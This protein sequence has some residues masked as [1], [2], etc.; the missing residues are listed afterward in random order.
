[1]FALSRTLT[2][3]YLGRH[4]T[5]T[6]LVVVTIALGVAVLVA[7]QALSRGL[8]AAALRG[9]NPLAVL[10][11]LMIVN[12][13]TGVPADLARQLRAAHL[14]GVKDARP[15]I[16]A[17][18]AVAD[19][20]NRSVILFGLEVGSE[21]R[22]QESEVRS[23]VTGGPG[24]DPLEVRVRK[25][26]RGNLWQQFQEV[27]A[28]RPLALVDE[29]LA[30]DLQAVNTKD[31]DHFRIR[32]GAKKQ[33]VTMF[34]TVGLGKVKTTE[35]YI[36]MDPLSASSV[37]FPDSPGTV[38][39]IHVRVEPGAD[40]QEVAQ[41]IRDWLG[42]R[43]T[44]KT[45]EE[46][47]DS[48]VSEVTGAME[49]A[50]AIGGAGALVVGLFLVYNVLSVGVA[51][52]RHDI[53]ILRS[54]GATRRQIAGLFVMEAAGLG[55]LGSA[56]GLPLGMG[57]AWGLLG[58]T[59]RVVSDLL[60]RTEE[61]RV[62]V[63]G[64]LLLFALLAGTLTAVVAA[65]VPALQ[66]AGEEPADAV[67]RVPRR[68]TVLLVVMQAAG[69]LLLVGVGALF[70]QF[71]AHLPTRFGVFAGIVLIVLGAMVATPLLATLI[72]RVVQPLF[73]YFLGLEG[74][75]AADNL[76]RSPGR[77]GLVVAAL[78]ATGGL[79][80][81]T[82]GFVCSSEDAIARWLE[83]KVGADLFVTS[84]AALTSG[85][86]GL[87]MDESLQP[88]LST[89][90]E[91][92]AVVSV[93]F[94][95]VEFRNHQVMVVAADTSALDAPDVS[96]R[97][98]ARTMRRFPRYHE[99][100]TCLVSENFAAQNGI[101]PGDRFTIPGPGG[102]K[103]DLEVL[104]TVEDYTWNRGTILVDRNWYGREFGD[105]QVDV[106]D[107]FLHP[108]AIAEDVREKITQRWGEQAV[109]V[110]MTQPEINKD[111]RSQLRRVYSMA[112]AQQ[113]VVGLVALL[114]VVVA[115]TISVLQRRREL[116]LLRAVGASRGQILRSVLAEAV[117]M[118]VTGA[119]VGFLIGLLLEWYVLDVM[120]LDEAGFVFPFKVPWIEAGVVFLLSVVCATLAGLWPAYHATRL[121]IPDAIAYE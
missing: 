44:V 62:D 46:F 59:S 118:G 107:V 30:A 4:L 42:N 101:Y 87:A 9:F 80:V 72:G 79:L 66:A 71:R 2:L 95:M 8:K 110:V 54:V 82:A 58:R 84:G 10:A 60:V 121:R 28:G 37:V 18:V 105:R 100:G 117:L 104:G 34:G 114:G 108:W 25:T 98:L 11:D 81:M 12:G 111:L 93:R 109:L 6:G 39:R 88:A 27:L 21:D 70:V 20:K 33:T 90:P 31:P 3:R 96:D 91:V 77:T 57:L 74:R 29:V 102:R 7:T 13:E 26:Y 43:G 76:A 67:R 40:I 36:V 69:A 68:N 38:G 35:N 16:L 19:L 112:Y 55:L 61:A 85:S 119:V 52:R 17:H 56:L 94:K 89:L 45:P 14:E 113:T 1:M 97:A 103:V 92:E 63:S 41:R 51:E 86:G 65:L 22:S 47:A 78:A 49:L 99:P 32:G 24:E 120:L 53:G 5:R 106:M 48:V 115:L 15:A 83:E 64:Q 50:L 75:L 73:R 116:G 23:Q